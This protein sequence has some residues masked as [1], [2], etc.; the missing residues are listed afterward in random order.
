MDV[1][2]GAR[3]VAFMSPKDDR[4]L[5]KII[6]ITRN[7][8]PAVATCTFRTRLSITNPPGRLAGLQNTDRNRTAR[9]PSF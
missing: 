1:V 4:G 3:G 2:E 7:L 5:K 6:L 8:P 9:P